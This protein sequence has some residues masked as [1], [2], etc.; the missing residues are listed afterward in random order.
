MSDLDRRQLLK[1]AL[2]GV[3]GMSILGMVKEIRA[4]QAVQVE[5]RAQFKPGRPVTAITLGA[6]SRGNVYGG[7]AQKYPA[8]LDIVGVAEPIAIRKQ[9]YMAKHGIAADNSF[10]TWEHVFEQ[11]K[12]ADA[13]IIST[14]DQLHYGPAIAALNM[15]YEVLLEKPISP[16]M[17]ECI[18]IRDLANKTGRTVAVCHVLRYTNYFKE[19][20]RLVEGGAVGKLISIQHLEPIQHEHMAHS[21]VRGNWHNSKTSTPII[22]G[23]SCHDLD[24]LHWIADQPCEQISAMGDL[25]WFHAGNAPEGSTAR[26]MDGCAVERECPYSAIKLYLEADRWS[27]VFD[28]P[29]DRERAAMDQLLAYNPAVA[30]KLDRI[31]GQAASTEAALGAIAADPALIA[32]LPEVFGPNWQERLIRYTSP[33]PE[34]LAIK[35][36]LLATTDYGRCVYRSDNDQPDHYVTNIR[37]AN[38]VTASFS[39]EAFTAYHGRRTRIMGSMGDIVGDENGM[40]HTDFRSGE[41]S[42]WE[43][44]ASTSGHGGGDYGLV[45]EWV[46]AISGDDK[47]LLSSTIDDSIESHAMAFAAERS[48][49]KS[50]VETL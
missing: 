37:F 41:V 15:G 16:S 21:Y 29:E 14:P 6:G 47:S 13:V 10:T 39:M 20:K 44:P 43:P 49:E 5:E 8:H 11:P 12:F 7:Y 9:R 45:F 27:Y 1:G 22:L 26:C 36:D 35:K 28:L 3:A 50:S 32:Q 46:R 19:L 40:V 33:N 18:E 34:L 2:A 48:R 17:A 31:A 25:S 4:A 23:K 42:E 30:V 24:I 38:D